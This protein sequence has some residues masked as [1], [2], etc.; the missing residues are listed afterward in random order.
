MKELCK[1]TTLDQLEVWETIHMPTNNKTSILQPK[2]ITKQPTKSEFN[3][4]Q[5]KLKKHT[6]P[7]KKNLRLSPSWLELSQYG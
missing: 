4:E 3:L 1:A 5:G 7:W 6:K 2:S